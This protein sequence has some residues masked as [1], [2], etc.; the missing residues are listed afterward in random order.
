MDFD[1]INQFNEQQKEAQDKELLLNTISSTATKITTA[2]NSS[3]NKTKT[4][5]VTNDL[6]KP[7]DIEKVV[8]AVKAIDLKPQDLQPIADALDQVSQAIAKLPT[9]YPEFPELPEAPEQ[10]EDVKVTNLNELKEYFQD[11]VTAVG[12]LQTSIKFDPKIEVKPA[13]V[14]VTEQKIDLTPVTKGLAN[15]EKAFKNIKTPNFDTTDILGGLESVYNSIN[16][17]SFPVPNYV[18]PFKGT[19]GEATQVQ[20]VNG[21]LPITGTIT[22]SSDGAIVDG[23]SSSI[24][25]TVKDLTN[26]NPLATQIM[27]ANG[28]A[29]TSFGGG[30]QY[31]AGDAVAPNSTGNALVFEDVGTYSTVTSGSPLPV[32][33]SSTK[34]TDAQLRASDVGVTDTTTQGLLTD[35]TQKTQLVDNG[36]TIT[37]DI[38]D[39]TNS[40]PL[41]T[42]LVDSNGDQIT[43]FGGGTQYTEG[44]IDAS[45]TGTAMM[46][47]NGSN[48]LKPLQVDTSGHL[49]VHEGTESIALPDGASNTRHVATD[50]AGNAIAEPSFGY[51]YNG[52]TWDRSRGDATNGTLVN[53][54]SNND[55]TV[56]GSVTVSATDLDIRNLA[57]ATDTVAIGDGTSTATVRNLAANDALNV[58]ITD[59]SGNQITSFGGGTQY[60]EGDVDASITGTALMME[61]AANALVAAPGTA[62]DGLLVNLGANNDVTVTGTVAVTQSGTWD[63]VGINDSGNSITVDNPQ[64]S[65]VGSG[66]EATAMRVTIATDSTG[67]LSVDDNGSSLTVDGTVTANLAAGTNN[68]GD[69]DVLTLPVAYNAGTTSATTVRTVEATAA[70]STLSNVAGSATSVTLIAANT[71]RKKVVM[72]NDSTADCY[73]KYGS[74]A[75]S[76]SFTWLMAAGSHIEET[77]Y[78]GII[79]GIWGSA[80]G[81]MRVTEIST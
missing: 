79:T 52:T 68:I 11:V 10:R 17:L 39:L 36:G 71:A 5:T 6:A 80:T 66:T 43:S 31:T 75:T 58:A 73:V 55:V 3:D 8:E 38:L 49:I 29:I 26:S 51:V 50:D 78:N 19:D 33:D 7:S 64:L 28:D 12:K 45:I 24:K 48:T 44:D 53:L 72:Y 18:L 13:D 77:D 15:L 16:N 2:I 34:L 25:A 70:T 9:E 59:G 46:A 27:D 32:V 41:V 23:V 65:V 61:G 67:V 42:A 47:E 60:T 69:V 22:A 20:L 35:G 76:S 81:N 21:A 63:E 56:T 37:A 74:A 30:T 40:N 14:K 57:P 62:A 1:K 54:G 4:V